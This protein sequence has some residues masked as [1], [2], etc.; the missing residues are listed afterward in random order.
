MA[1]LANTPTKFSDETGIVQSPEI[2]VQNT[3]KT[4][5]LSSDDINKIDTTSNAVDLVLPSATT[6]T[7][8]HLLYKW[9]AGSNEAKVTAFGAE[10][11]NGA[12]NYIFGQIG[13]YLWIVSDG[14]TWDIYSSVDIGGAD[15]IVDITGDSGKFSTLQAAVDDNESNGG[16]RSYIVRAGDYGAVSITKSI[17]LHGLG[18]V[19]FTDIDFPGTETAVIKLYNMCGESWVD[20]GTGNIFIQVNNFE[21]E[22]DGAGGTLW[23]SN[24]THTSSTVEFHQVKINETSNNG[25]ALDVNGAMNFD[26]SNLEILRN[27]GNGTSAKV[28][29]WDSNGLFRS[30]GSTIIQ[31][32]FDCSDTS[33]I[34]SFLGA[35][36]STNGG[37]DMIRNANFTGVISIFNSAVTSVGGEMFS[38]SS[39]SLFYGSVVTVATG[40]TNGTD[41]TNYNVVSVAGKT[42]TITL[43]SGD[44]GLGNVD[45][46]ADLGK[47]ISTATQTALDA[48]LTAIATGVTYVN[49]LSDLSDLLESGTYE[50]PPGY[51]QFNNSIDFG[52]ADIKLMDLNGCY[53]FRGLCIDVTLTY[54]DTSPF[55]TD[56][57]DGIFLQWENMQVDT[58]NAA[59]FLLNNAGNSLI[60]ELVVFLNSGVQPVV[61]NYAFLTTKYLIFIGSVTGLL[62]NNVKTISCQVPQYNNGQ[63]ISGTFL[64]ASGANSE[65]LTVSDVDSRPE[66]NESMF[67]IQA[68]YGGLVSM[69]GGVHSLTGGSFFKAGSRNHNDKDILVNSIQNV[70]SSKVGAS[71]HIA[72]GDEAPSTVADGSALLILGTFTEDSAA[73][74]TVTAAGRLTY[75]G[76]PPVDLPFISKWL[77]TPATGTNKEY[78]FYLRKNGTDLIPISYDPVKADSGS[79]SKASVMGDVLLVTND[80]L[81][82][83]VVGD[84]TTTSM[85]ASGLSF[86]LG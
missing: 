52:T 61:D 45:N 77:V 42:G 4:I 24:N 43:D 3:S 2:Q 69:A 65:R 71:I 59:P 21:I 72:Q 53:F 11:I 22:R 27:G 23:I 85:T 50:L 5:D 31:G 62:A 18:N 41:I 40:R 10:K 14:A 54:A 7:G 33:A 64:T 8:V 63:N 9:S 58:P 12:S 74:F 32:I 84:G 6:A 44:V 78:D 38:D 80:Y 70:S 76:N 37:V 15:Y 47:P 60:I 28:V 46:T 30:K 55:V 67:D 29:D 79:P 26:G 57:A 17:T 68:N 25:L 49:T 19:N 86:I 39:G 75:I 13:D 34:I 82:L 83:V 35:N 16:G 1:T 48:K 56:N 36:M 66:S 73:E 51:Y 81:E 20:N